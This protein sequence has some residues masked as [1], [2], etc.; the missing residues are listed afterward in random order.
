VGVCLL[1][2]QAVEV[3]MAVSKERMKEWESKEQ[4]WDARYKAKREKCR[5][6]QSTFG[7][8]AKV[9]SEVLNGTVKVLGFLIRNR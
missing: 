5:E 4:E 7:K 9:S 2:F 3:N 1:N 6:D 8:A